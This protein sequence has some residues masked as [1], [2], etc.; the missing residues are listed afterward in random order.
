M[1]SRADSYAFVDLERNQTVAMSNGG[2][3]EAVISASFSFM[4]TSATPTPKNVTMLTNALTRPFWS[5]CDNA[6]MSVVMRVMIRPA[7]SFS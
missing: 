1:R 7:I 2:T 4:N 3:I 6:S 5:S